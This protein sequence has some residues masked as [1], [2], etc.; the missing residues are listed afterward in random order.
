MEK[1]LGEKL[2]NKILIKPVF[3]NNI[4]SFTKDEESTEDKKTVKGAKQNEYIN[5]FLC[6]N[7]IPNKNKEIFSKINI[8]IDN[9]DILQEQKLLNS[10]YLNFSFC[11][12]FNNS[13]N[14]IFACKK[15]HHEE[16]SKIQESQENM[17]E[18][19][20]NS[21]KIKKNG[22]KHK[23]PAYKKHDKMEKDNIVR[24]IQVHYCNFLVFFLNEVIQKIIIDDIYK[25]E[26]AEEINYMKD[27]LFNNIDYKFKSNIKKEFMKTTENMIIK[28]IISPPKD[29][30][31]KNN[32]SNKN[33]K[34]M[35]KIELKNNPILNKIL[36]QKYLYYFNEIYYQNK[37]NIIF[38]EGDESINIIL[39]SNTKMLEDLISKNKGDINYISKL[40]RVVMQNFSKPKYIFK[41]KK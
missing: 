40:K 9:D 29:F 36:S 12:N 28:D 37:K 14:L 4:S 2:E 10:K 23:I 30:C 5:F 1:I 8:S 24:K 19:I 27:Y 39:S 11:E 7:N 21:E 6:K 35:Q 41:T 22:V 18:N 33:E 26:N 25:T 32:I 38:S 3:D 17:A 31:K 20:K 34:I 15:R 16:N 13:K